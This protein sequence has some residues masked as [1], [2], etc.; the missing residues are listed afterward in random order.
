MPFR[1]LI[2]NIFY[3]YFQKNNWMTGD[4]TSYLDDNDDEG[5]IVGL[6]RYLLQL[7]LERPTRAAVNRVRKDHQYG[8]V[9]LRGL[10]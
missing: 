8:G 4:L 9:W 6:A 1:M 10:L 5:V 2:R 7:G 3:N